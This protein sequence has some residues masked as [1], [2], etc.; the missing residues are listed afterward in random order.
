VL[1]NISGARVD[2]LANFNGDIGP[3]QVCKH[4]LAACFLGQGKKARRRS[5]W[6]LVS[7]AALCAA[8][9]IAASLYFP[10]RA[11]Q[12]WQRLVS[13]LAREPGIV[14]IE[15]TRRDGKYF[16]SGLR[17]PLAREP[18]V[19]LREAGFSPGEVAFAW[20]G[21][22]S[23]QQP[24]AAIRDFEEAKK[25]VENR[26]IY[27]KLDNSQLSPDQVNNVADVGD[28]IHRL[29][30]SAERAAKRVKVEVTGRTDISGTESRN[31]KLAEERARTVI[32]TLTAAGVPSQTFS[33]QAGAISATPGAPDGDW[34]RAYSR[35]VSFGV[36]PVQP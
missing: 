24:F 13:S 16:V 17:D 9:V 34:A 21:Y 27:F 8:I 5:G 19:L 2:A 3:F 29:L 7:V 23:L 1:Q 10:M 18:A 22:L 20:Q 26:K 28:A 36:V 35:C 12:R 15:A 30:E 14:V 6:W 4:D 11:G 32:A 25:N 33:T 31:A